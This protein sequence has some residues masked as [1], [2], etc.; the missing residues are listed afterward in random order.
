[1]ALSLLWPRER[2]IYRPSLLMRADTDIAV[3]A[4]SRIA[5]QVKRVLLP[6]RA[7]SALDQRIEARTLK[8]IA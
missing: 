6:S 1:M 2:N 8:L 3:I 7:K 4:F 5:S